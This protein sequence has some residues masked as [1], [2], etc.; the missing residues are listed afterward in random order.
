VKVTECC[1]TNVLRLCGRDD[2]QGV[3][4]ADHLARALKLK[5]IADP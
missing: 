4:A 2:Q 1:L 5:K 3:V